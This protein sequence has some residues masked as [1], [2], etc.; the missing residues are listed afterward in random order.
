M[1]LFLCYAGDP[2]FR[3]RVCKTV[4]LHGIK[5]GPIETIW[6]FVLLKLYSPTVNNTNLL[7]Q[8]VC[9]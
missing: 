5:S 8:I 3:R 6:D 1:E 4:N 2:G 9:F 7:Q